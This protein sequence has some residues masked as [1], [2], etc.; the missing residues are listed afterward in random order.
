MSKLN[1]ESG[2]LF[3]SYKIW[4]CEVSD[5][6]EIPQTSWQTLSIISYCVTYLSSSLICR[7]ILAFRYFP[8]FRRSKHWLVIGY[9][10]FICAH[11]RWH[12][13]VICESHKK[14]V[15]I[16]DISLTEQQFTH[17]A[18]VTLTLCPLDLI[19]TL[20]TG[21][22]FTH[23]FSIAIEIRWKFRFT[24]LSILIQWSQQNFV[25]GTTAVL[26]WHVKKFVS[27][28]WPAT[29]LQQG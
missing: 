28:W 13:S 16:L 6:S 14:L 25:H 21:P 11:L 12:A 3:T 9:H 10:V 4:V 15:N 7:V 5:R 1:N 8:D 19:Y 2:L 18:L 23:G 24:L 22:R 17:G 26:S 29:E 27:I 20:K